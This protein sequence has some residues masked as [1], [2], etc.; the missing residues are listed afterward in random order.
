[1]IENVRQELDQVGEYYFDRKTKLLYVKPNSTSDLLDFRVGLLEQILDLTGTNNITIENIGFRDTVP[2][3]H[4]KSSWSAP[5]GGDWSLHRGGAIFLENV[6]DVTIRD[7]RFRRLDGN[8]I[9][10]S[11]RTRNVTIESSHFEWLGENAIATWGDTDGFDA[12][13]EEFPMYT[14]IRRN[15]MR[16]LGIFEKQSSAVGHAKAAHTYIIENIMFNLPRAAINFNDMVGGGDIVQGNLI[17]N[18]CRESGDHGPIN[19][20]DRQPFLTTLRDGVTKSFEPLPREINGNFIIANYGAS[21]GVDNDDGSSW[22]HIHHNLFYSAEGFKMDYGTCVFSSLSANYHSVRRSSHMLLSLSGGHDSVFEDNLIMAFPYDGSQCF[23]MG[24]F[25]KG[26]GDILRRNR[27]LVGLGHKMDSGCGDPSCSSPTPES[28]ESQQIVGYLWGSC[29]DSAVVLSENEYFTPDG[30]AKIGCDDGAFPLEE[31]QTKY[32]REI[33]ST[34]SKLPDE[35][36]MIQW[37][38]QM[39]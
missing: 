13:A 21:Q 20:W 8:A 37:A 23:N 2:T 31:M 25:N 32:G 1:M 4:P 26:H 6:T 22:F 38:K 19:S 33:G 14:T 29:K 9:F 28:D 34:H 12:T 24:D 35:E 7:C 3:Y 5:S 27:C 10:L 16:E 30:K 36:T 15:V 17:F 11:R 39:L 18:T